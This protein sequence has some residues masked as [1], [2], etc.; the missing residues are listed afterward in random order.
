MMPIAR[1]FLFA[2]GA[3]GQPV[4]ATPSRLVAPGANEG[5]FQD[6]SAAN[7]RWPTGRVDVPQSARVCSSGP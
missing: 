3:L 6:T 1:R 4:T 7:S 5:R 2:L